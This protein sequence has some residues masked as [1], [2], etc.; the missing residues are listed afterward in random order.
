MQVKVP[1]VNRCCWCLPLRPGIILFA[2][3]NIILSVLSLICLLVTTELHRAS[4][5][6]DDSISI[7]TSSVLYSLLG[8]GVIL[9][10]LLLVGGYQKDIS[11]LRLY[12]Y[13]AV[14]AMLASLVPIA[15]L[16][17]KEM[18]LEIF[19]SLF[20]VATQ[21]YVIVL[22]RSEVVKLEENEL[23]SIAEVHAEVQEQVN[24]SERITLV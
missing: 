20:V 9:N 16:I 22:V 6:P 2:Y 5:T 14:A 15:I 17:F 10:F 4:I 18:F 11:M 24:V 19:I 7:M 3:I 21:F 23:R 8:M 12:I 13:Y 1:A